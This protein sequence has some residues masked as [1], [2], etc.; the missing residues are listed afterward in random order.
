MT[1]KERAFVEA[2]YRDTFSVM[3]AYARRM[4]ANESLAEEAVQDAF[5]VVCERV[6]EVI[7][8]DNPQG[9]AMNALKNV[10]KAMIREKTRSA[11]LVG[12]VGASL[13]V[14]GGVSPPDELDPDLLYDDIR[15][16]DDYK[17]LRRFADSGMTIAELAHEL[18]IPPETLKKRL[19]RA[20]KRLQKFF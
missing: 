19:Q 11:E 5:R 6:G 17:L 4:L 8:L 7:L 18:D 20:K 14:G 10:A 15:G 13:T 16:T 2:L 3:L 1:S 9:W 12:R